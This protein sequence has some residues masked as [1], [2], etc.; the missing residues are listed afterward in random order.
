[1]PSGDG[2]VLFT[3]QQDL[4]RIVTIILFNGTVEVIDT[5]TI[6]DTLRSMS[7]RPQII[8]E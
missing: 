6:V 2:F 3:K 8:S 7:E 4:V 5:A 1:M